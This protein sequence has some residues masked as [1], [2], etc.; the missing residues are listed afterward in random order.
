ME[1]V[2]VFLFINRLDDGKRVPFL[3]EQQIQQK[4][5]HSTVSVVEGVDGDK[6][7]VEDGG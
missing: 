4:P 5:A 7:I 1:A 6:F 3:D 2:V